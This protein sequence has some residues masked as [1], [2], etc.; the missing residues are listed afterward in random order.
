MDGRRYLDRTDRQYDVVLVNLPPPG[1][2]QLNRFYTTEFFTS[3]KSRM[4]PRAVLSVPLQGMENYL[5]TEAGRLYSVLYH[6]LERSFR[7]IL[8]VPGY[9]TYFIASDAELDIDIPSR[10]DSLDIVTVYVNSFYLDRGLLSDRSSELQSSISETAEINRDLHPRAFFL[11]IN[12]W[13]SYFGTN[14]WIL[15]GVF[16]ILIALI[17]FRGGTLGTGIFI[18]GFTGM[19]IEIVLLLAVQATFGFVYLYTAIIL[20]VFMMG[21]ASGSLYVRR[22]FPNPRTKQFPALQV[23]LAGCVF[24]VFWWLLLIDGRSVPL[25]FLHS[26]FLVLTFFTSFVSGLLF[27]TAALLRKRSIQNVAGDLYSSDLAGSAAG[28]LIVSVLMVP[29]LGMTTS[30]LVLLLLNLLGSLNSLLRKTY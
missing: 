29:L 18:T 6:T 27:A 21:L 24:L 5:S 23:I 4:N 20:T 2:A 9:K 14:L 30:L 13:L 16:L 11:Q 17:G 8:L 26:A 3:L 28:A 10:I 1:S 7:N 15:L 12:H 25:V 19:G 22:I